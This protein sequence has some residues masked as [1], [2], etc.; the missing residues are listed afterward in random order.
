[1]LAALE[2]FLLVRAC[3][4]CLRRDRAAA[5]PERRRRVRER[6]GPGVPSRSLSAVE[7]RHNCA[8]GCAMKPAIRTKESV[9][10][11]RRT[12]ARAALGA[13]AAACLAA[14]PAAADGWHRGPHWYGCGGAAGR[15][16]HRPPRGGPGAPLL[17]APPRGVCA[18]PLLPARPRPRPPPPAGPPRPV[19]GP[20]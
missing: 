19:R 14:A 12:V 18:P 1:M 17:Y 5:A 4:W 10:T 8:R 15:R 11:I 16:F 7:L 9:M 20:S 13:A 3:G 2:Y 6:H